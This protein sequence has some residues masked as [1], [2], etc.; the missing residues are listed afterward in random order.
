MAYVKQDLV[1]ELHC[2]AAEH[3]RYD[4]PIDLPA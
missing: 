3:Y 1:N 2:V 4:V